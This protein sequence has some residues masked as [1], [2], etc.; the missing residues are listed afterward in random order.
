MMVT[1]T[2]TVAAAV[3]GGKGRKRDELRVTAA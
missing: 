2:A 3:Y 1:S